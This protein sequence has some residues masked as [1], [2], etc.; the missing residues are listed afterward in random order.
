MVNGLAAY[1]G[2][3]E[4][5]AEVITVLKQ[6]IEVMGGAA[7]KIMIML[8]TVAPELKSYLVPIAQAG[9]ALQSEVEAM[10]Q[11]MG[12]QGSAVSP[13]AAPNPAGGADEMA[14]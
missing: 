8:G 10:E 5:Q 2:P 9:K 11:R 12:G 1:S 14:A 7:K 13:A 3:Q 6:Q 4:D